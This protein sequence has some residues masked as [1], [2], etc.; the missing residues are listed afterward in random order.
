VT[1]ARAPDAGPRPR[2]EDGPPT[3]SASN[4]SRF[5][6]IREERYQPVRAWRAGGGEGVLITDALWLGGLALARGAELVRVDVRGTNGRRV[7]VF[8]LAGEAAEQAARDFYG[9]TSVDVSLL[10]LQVRRLK[11]LAFQTL[12]Q[13]QEQEEK[14]HEVAEAGGGP[15]PVAGS[16]HR[17]HRR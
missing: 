7:A 8:G 14:R 12:R 10:K 11:E 4:L 1:L 17:R 9:T 15:Q 6:S 16:L 2:G 3:R 13:Q 5:S